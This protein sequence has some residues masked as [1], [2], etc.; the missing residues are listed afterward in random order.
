MRCLIRHINHYGRSG[1]VYKD[2]LVDKDS[3]TIGRSVDQDLF[4]PDLRVALQ[5][6]VISEL[7]NGHYLLQARTLSGIRVNERLSQS[8]TLNIG[9]TLRIGNTDIKVKQIP[10]ES[11]NDA[12]DFMLEVDNHLNQAQHQDSSHEENFKLHNQADSQQIRRWSWWLFSSILILFFAI[13]WF[14]VYMGEFYEPKLIALEEWY[15]EDKE[16]YVSLPPLPMLISDRFWNSGTVASAHHFFKEDCAT[17]HEKAFEKVTDKA[18]VSCHKKTYHHV[19]PNFFDLD[20]L[21]NSPCASCHEDHNGKRQLVQR[22]D[23]LCSQCHGN[24]KVQI[25]DDTVLEDASDFEHD[26]PA[27]KPTLISYEDGQEITE[28]DLMLQDVNIR[29]FSNLNFPHAPHVS[30][31]GLETIDGIF[32]LWCDDC[33]IHEPGQ[34]HFRPID[35]NALC[36]DCHQLSFE[37]TDPF[38]V[39]PHGQSGE[40]MHVL[41]EYYATRALE[42]DYHGDGD[43]PDIVAQG[44]FPGESL[45]G[46]ERMI[47]LDWARNKAEEVAADVFEFSLCIECHEVEKVK[48]DPPRWEIAPVRI[49]QHFLPR[50]KYNHDKH[51]TMNCTTCHWAAESE[52]SSDLLLPT[53]DSCQE[54]HGGIHAENKLQSTCVDCHGFHVATEFVMGKEEDEED[55]FA[56]ENN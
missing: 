55:V 53:I 11:H 37:A 39:V 23:T 24:L 28:R 47:A 33:H 21:H 54:C 18:C 9:D 48:D 45:T 13:P 56:D 15:S 20:T 22:D 30:R 38:R 49:N 8:A 2:K 52:K 42:G 44:R 12:P 35:F 32:R 41:Q 19:D 4:L 17:C 51:L 29:E 7:P 25:G 43:V 40:V 3:L 34:N 16:E 14:S 50:A 6:A 10:I 26:H 1:R 46:E 5:H 31:K 27:F 36:K